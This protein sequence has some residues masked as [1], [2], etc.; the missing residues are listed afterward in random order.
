MALINSVLI[1]FNQMNLPQYLEWAYN[2]LKPKNKFKPK[3]T[4]TN[5]M[6]ME[7]I[8]KI[9]LCSTHFLKNFIK[10]AKRNKTVHSHIIKTLIYSFTLLQN[11]SSLEQIENY[12]IN[13]YYIFN[14]PHFDSTVKYSLEALRTEC[15]NRNLNKY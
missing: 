12:L 13:I 5:F 11:S 1:S 6:E 2:Y 10:K 3:Y 14:N 9:Y 7:N 4:S 8:T 15:I